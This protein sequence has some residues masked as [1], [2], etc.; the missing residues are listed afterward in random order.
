MC[1]NRPHSFIRLC[2]LLYSDDVQE[3]A[4]CC[5]DENDGNEGSSSEDVASHALFPDTTGDLDATSEVS[6]ARGG[7]CLSLSA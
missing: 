4:F 1:K 2:A 6:W 3:C 7:D 5:A